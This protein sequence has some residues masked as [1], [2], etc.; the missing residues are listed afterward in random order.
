VYSG[1]WNGVD[2]AVKKFKRTNAR[3][4]ELLEHEVNLMRCRHHT[5]AVV[6]AAGAEN[7]D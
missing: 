4:A 1:Q 7:G 3:Q 2:V 5:H 6:A